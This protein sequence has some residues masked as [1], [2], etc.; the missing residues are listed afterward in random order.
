LLALR[1]CPKKNP[2]KPSD[3]RSVSFM[4]SVC[5]RFKEQVMSML[6]VTQAEIW[7][8]LGISSKDGSE[9]IGYLY[10]LDEKIISEPQ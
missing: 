5:P 9:I 10:L 4:I 3:F 6:S 1:K 8:A 7:K 2:G